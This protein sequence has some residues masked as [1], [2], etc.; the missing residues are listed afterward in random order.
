MLLFISSLSCVVFVFMYVCVCVFV[1]IVG[2]YVNVYVAIPVELQYFIF[3]QTFS[4]NTTR[5]LKSKL[6]ASACFLS[7]L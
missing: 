7:T 2:V 4:S 6:R 3:K 5:I 1:C